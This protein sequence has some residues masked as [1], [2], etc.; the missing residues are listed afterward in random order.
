M[1]EALILSPR[2]A[3]FILRSVLDEVVDHDGRKVVHIFRFVESCA[4]RVFGACH[5]REDPSGVRVNRPLF[6]TRNRNRIPPPH[7]SCLFSPHQVART[8]ANT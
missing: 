8:E 5:V 3:S 6:E 4:P 7:P 1:Q 2:V